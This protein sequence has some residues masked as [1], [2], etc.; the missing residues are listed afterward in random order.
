MKYFPIFTDLEDAEVLVAGGAEQ[1][2]QKVRLLLKTDARIMIV[3]DALSPELEGLAKQGRVDFVRRAFVDGDI[4]GKRLAYAATGDRALDAAV[5]RAAQAH[6]V[7]VNVVYVPELSTFIT[8]AIVDRDPV[9]V[10]IGTEGSAP[11][12]AREIKTR[13][14]AWLPANL[15]SRRGARKACAILLTIHSRR[16]GAPPAVGA[17]AAGPFRHAVLGGAEA[18]A[19]RVLAVELQ[20]AA[21]PSRVASL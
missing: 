5:S 1:A 2:A 6:G 7:P 10:A 3:A 11:V 17:T 18:E 13:L 14:E 20:G 21:A 19:Q 15:G 12:L 8:P 4:V 9:R 16:Q